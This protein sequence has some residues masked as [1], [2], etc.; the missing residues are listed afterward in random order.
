LLDSLYG[1]IYMRFLI[2]HDTLTEEF[3]NNLCR[4]VLGSLSAVAKNAK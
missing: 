3:V 1:A 4:Q 2:R